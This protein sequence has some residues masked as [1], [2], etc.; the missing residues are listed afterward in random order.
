[1]HQR[2]LAED[3]QFAI[4]QKRENIHL[5]KKLI[6][7]RK[8]NL[9]KLGEKNQR[10]ITVNRNSQKQVPTYI[11]KCQ[12]F[13]DYIVRTDERND[14]LN[15]ERLKLNEQLKQCRV[16]NI[17]KLLKFIFPISKRILKSESSASQI[18]LAISCGGSAGDLG[19]GAN[20]VNELA[21]ATRTAYVRGKWILQDSHGEL[22][23]VIVAPALPGRFK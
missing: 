9:K 4:K 1:M 5:L 15:E 14:K 7:E 13:A 8:I 22:Q 18:D 6:D 17:Q 19:A 10:L 12:H 11:A 16:Q 2:K 23:H 3:L 20:T 21:E